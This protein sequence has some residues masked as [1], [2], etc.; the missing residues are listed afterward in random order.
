MSHAITL[1]RRGAANDEIPV[2]AVIANANG[3]VIAAAH[4]LTKAGHNA[5]FHA[6]LLVIMDACKRLGAMRLSEFDLFV[7]LEPCAMCA[8]AISHAR[9]KRVYFAN[10]DPKGGAV[11]H[12]AKWFDQ[13]TCLHRPEIIGGFM[14][15][16]AKD[17]LPDFFKSLR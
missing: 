13:K 16:E 4:N 3:K 6:E 1:A 10:Y 15:L 7:T 2:G 9:L 11:D 5:L 8:A 12:G 14:E 17:L